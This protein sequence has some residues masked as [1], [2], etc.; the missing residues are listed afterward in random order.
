MGAGE[1]QNGKLLWNLLA[2]LKR[3]LHAF[4]SISTAWLR[5]SNMAGGWVGAAAHA[6]QRRDSCIRLLLRLIRNESASP[7][8]IVGVSLRHYARR[9]NDDGDL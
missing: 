4:A 1:F 5:V 3:V 7:G 2:N 9:R 8:Q 6:V